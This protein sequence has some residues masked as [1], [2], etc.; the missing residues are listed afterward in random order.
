MKQIKVETKNLIFSPPLSLIIIII[1]IGNFNN[2]LIGIY[3]YFC[4]IISTDTNFPL[5]YYYSLYI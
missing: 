4:T 1:K 3:D 5:N 2:E